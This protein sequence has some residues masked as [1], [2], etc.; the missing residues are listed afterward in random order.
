MPGEAPVAPRTVE[1]RLVRAFLVWAPDFERQAREFEG[2]EARLTGLLLA[3]V[4]SLA[5]RR[6]GPDPDGREV[7]RFVARSITTGKEDAARRREA[8]AV[9]WFLIGDLELSDV[10]SSDVIVDVALDVSQPLI[11]ELDQTPADLDALITALEDRVAWVND[12]MVQ[13]P[14]PPD[15]GTLARWDEWRRRLGNTFAE[16]GIRHV[17]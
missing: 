6:F 16:H 13:L 5:A 15:H 7:T 17:G 3:A 14:Q 10:L 8:E 4:A 9:I 1:G 12:Y 2:D 11:A